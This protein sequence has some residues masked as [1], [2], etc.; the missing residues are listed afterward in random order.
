MQ[1]VTDLRAPEASGLCK[2]GQVQSMTVIQRLSGPRTPK[3][4]IQSQSTEVKI[5][6]LSFIKSATATLFLLIPLRTDQ[7][8][9]LA[10]SFD[11]CGRDRRRARDELSQSENER[12]LEGQPDARRPDP[13]STNPGL[14]AGVSEGLNA[15]EFSAEPLL[16]C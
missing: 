4:S 9:N 14:G 11:S 6:R 7:T 15:S 5:G 1:Q 8:P 3:F 12:N 10:M 2:N 13:P 16:L